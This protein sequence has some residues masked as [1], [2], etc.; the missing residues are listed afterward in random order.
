MPLHASF[1]DQPEVRQGWRVLAILSTLMGFASISTDLFLPAIPTMATALRAD[2]GTV[3]LT[4]SSYLIG[5]SLGQLFWG[6]ISDRHGRRGPVAAGLVLF[7][8]GS[9]GCALSGS[10]SALIG[11]RV[12][13]ALG[14]SAS[15]VLARAMV[16]DL[17]AGAQA[18]R[19]MS[20][21]IAIMAI[22]PLVGPL[23]G[24]EIL[25]FAGWRAIFFTLVGIGMATLAALSTLE[26]T[27]TP[28]R[29][30]TE[31]LSRAFAEYGQL[32]HHR[33]LLAYAGAAGC[34]FGGTFGYI[35]A[36]PFA[37]ITIHHLPPQLYGLLF[38]AGIVGIMVTSTLNGRLVA[39]IGSDR[40]LLWGAT[41]AALASVVLAVTAQTGWGGLAGLAVPMF[42]F[43]ATTGLIA[44]NAAAGALA[45]FPK[46]AGAVSALFGAFQYG[47]GIL[48]SALVG[49]FADG[50][51]WPM[52][53]V[54][55]VGGIGTL[56][57]ARTVSA[58]SF[59]RSADVYEAT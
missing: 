46:Q 13:Q 45:D 38:G 25:A 31:P 57:C 6:P 55:G 50:T 15:V 36:S 19:M 33:R 14:A 3:E 18:A 24:G 49:T 40:L 30:S 22:A 5:F 47:G 7:L 4:I 9:A 8:I 1:R 2:V 56:L 42:V 51:A 29:R 43:V 37:Y 12:V 35:A 59:S 10:A 39:R 17:Y 48:G 58:I 53:L 27:L 32:F 34:F 23:V 44:G 11:W 28:S 16:R 52:G 20:T 41:G 21:L 26:E 54:V